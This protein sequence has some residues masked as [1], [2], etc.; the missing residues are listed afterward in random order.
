[1]L[2][3]FETIFYQSPKKLNIYIDNLGRN[4]HGG[5][6]ENSVEKAGARGVSE[7]SGWW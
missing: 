4:C 1:M 3:P 7:K 6:I 5:S 2:R